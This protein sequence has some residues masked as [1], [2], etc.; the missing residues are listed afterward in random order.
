MLLKLKECEICGLWRDLI[1]Y[2]LI[3]RD[4]YNKFDYYVVMRSYSKD[5]M[6]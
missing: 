4:K 5:Y 6:D 1:C 3:Y 2:I